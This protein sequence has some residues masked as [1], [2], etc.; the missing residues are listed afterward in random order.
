MRI[1]LLSL[2][3][4]GFVVGCYSS[5]SLLAD[6]LISPDTSVAPDT[7]HDTAWDVEL[8]P[9]SDPDPDPV[10]DPE[11][12]VGPDI[13]L[14][15]MTDAWPDSDL[16]SGAAVLD[17]SYSAGTEFFHWESGAGDIPELHIFG[18]YETRSDHH[19][20]YHPR[21]EGIVYV[22]STTPV[23]LGLS[24]YEPTHWT[25]VTKTPGSI[26]EVICNGSYEPTATVPEGVP[27]RILDP[28]LPYGYGHDGGGGD[29]WGLIHGLES[30]TGVTYASFSGCY[31]AT[32]F[33]VTT[34]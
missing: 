26:V 3:A 20:G 19:S 31:N 2:A 11:L 24:S 5:E 23:I 28:N 14:D 15:S 27:V 16:P 30:L 8:T 17:C 13:D 22:D 1:P 18:V 7:V 32:R 21:G 10:P 12:D 29:T 9:D 34:P 25:V 33:S 6:P 4:V